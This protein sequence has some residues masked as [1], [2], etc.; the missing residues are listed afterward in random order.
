MNSQNEKRG[1][2]FDLDGTLI[3]QFE[4]IHSAFSKTLVSMGF[5]APSYNEVRR[6]VGGASEATM[7]KLIGPSRAK[8]GVNKLR[9]IFEKEMFCGLK[10]LPG[11]MEGIQKIKASNFKC[12]VLTNKYGPHARSACK[13]LKI[14]QYLEFTIGAND[15]KWK[16]PD[17]NLTKL[18]LREIGVPRKQT[19]YVGDSPYD[20]ETARNSNLSCH[21]VAT[22]THSFNELSELKAQ[23]THQD[24]KSL[25]DHLLTVRKGN[26]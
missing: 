5:S 16:K 8:E 10:L 7:T 1:I 13:H 18:A 24:F 12:A 9:P 3:D 22:G 19:V 14:D 11:V 17:P 6:A 4:A 23:S 25:T 26:V 20:Y 21:L 2:L 15:T